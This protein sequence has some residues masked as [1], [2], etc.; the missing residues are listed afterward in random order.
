MDAKKLADFQA[1]LRTLM[2]KYNVE[3]QPVIQM[4]VTDIPST[5]VV[6]EAVVKES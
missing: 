2:I 4:Q 5:S 1:E 3:M 6:E